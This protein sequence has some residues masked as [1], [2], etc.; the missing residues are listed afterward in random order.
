VCGVCGFNNPF[1]TF[2]KERLVTSKAPDAPPEKMANGGGGIDPA[3]LVVVAVALLLVIAWLARRL[4]WVERQQRRLRR[5]LSR[6]SPTTDVNHTHVSQNYYPT[7]I[8]R[9]PTPTPTPS[10]FTV[11]R[12]AFVDNSTG[13]NATATLERPDLPYLTI[14]AAIDAAAVAAAADGTVNWQVQIRPGLF[15]EDLE[16]LSGVDLLGVTAS[17]IP[18]ANPLEVIVVGSMAWSEASVGGSASVALQGILFQSTGTD[19]LFIGDGAAPRSLRCTGCAFVAQYLNSTV[20]ELDLT[21]ITLKEGSGTTLTLGT[22]VLFHDC[23][24]LMKITRDTTGN[25]YSSVI[26]DTSIRDLQLLDSRIAMVSTFAS[27]FS[28]IN[29]STVEFIHVAPDGNGASSPVGVASFGCTYTATVT[30]PTAATGLAAAFWVIV[31]ETVGPALPI[32]FVSHCDTID[33]F[34]RGP[35]GADPFSTPNLFVVSMSNS[36]A[37]EDVLVS[38]LAVR[39]D[40]PATQAPLWST[41][42]VNDPS[43]CTLQFRGIAC[44]GIEEFL[45]SGYSGTMTSIGV[46]DIFAEPGTSP[47]G[48]FY[49]GTVYRAF[50][51]YIVEPQDA[52]LIATNDSAL[53]DLVLPV[54]ALYPGRALII[55]NAQTVQIVTI[56]VSGPPSGGDFNL[57]Y[58]LAASSGILIFCDG[59]SWWIGVS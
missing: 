17:G 53:T 6:R 29:D 32:R 59:T 54:P 52:I 24:I 5:R 27:G 1:P 49:P 45:T 48:Q 51:S 41:G 26:L 57:P 44:S 19:V 16:L 7:N 4:Q 20:P 23:S 58:P 22:S 38:D 37:P 39:S 33:V 56:T 13:N 25:G 40:P 30:Q 12:T 15:T 10:F 8:I 2:T 34:T 43:M 50:G 36:T 42:I 28:S 55:K 31:E 3:L 9:P 35:S 18:L 47:V 46:T 11:S 14:Q 21:C